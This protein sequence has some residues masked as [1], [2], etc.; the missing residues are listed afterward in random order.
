M[1]LRGR[2]GAYA[3]GSGSAWASVVWLFQ[4]SES[5]RSGGP[6]KARLLGVSPEKPQLARDASRPYLR[7]LSLGTAPTICGFSGR[8]AIHAGL[9]RGSL[10]RPFDDP[11]AD[12]DYARPAGPEERVTTTFCGT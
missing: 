7:L 12:A 6:A 10:A 2:D 4:M 8:N 3:G 9:F 11:P 1:P 5:K